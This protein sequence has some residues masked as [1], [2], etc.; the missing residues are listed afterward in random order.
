M[1]NKMA[2]KVLLNTMALYTRTLFLTIISLFSYRIVLDILGAADY[3]TYNVVG[4]FVTMFA[5][6]S[7]TMTV[8]TQRYFS[9][10]FSQ[11]SIELLN[12]LFSVNL[13]IYIFLAI[14]ILLLG[15]YAIGWQQ[16]IKRLPLTTAFANKAVTV[17]WGII[18]GAV[19]FQE[20]VTIGKV[21]GA[22]LVILGVVVYANAD[23]K[24]K[25]E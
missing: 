18:W 7:G 12:K 17:V 8:A 5:F 9:V 24:V 20:K 4:G 19:F 3:G 16:I 23:G 1:I 14:I 15:F 21:I 25:D 11:K 6:I 13:I 2:N 10:G 22:I